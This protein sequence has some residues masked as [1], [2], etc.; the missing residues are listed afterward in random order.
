MDLRELRYFLSVARLRSFTKA[1]LHLR[2]AQ[3]ALSRQVRKLEEELGVPLLVRTGRK[4]ELTRAGMRLFEEGQ[5]LVRAINQLEEDAR[6]E[7][8]ELEAT[9]VIGVPPA[10]GELLMPHILARASERYPG[11]R[12]NIVEG[13]SGFLYERLLN[14]ELSLAL[15]YK[16]APRKDLDI[17]PLVQTQLHLIGPPHKIGDVTPADASRVF[18]DGLP[19]ILPASMHS[20]RVL[21]GE[22]FARHGKTLRLK[23]EVDGLPLT[24]TL[25][26]LGFAFTILT[27]DAVYQQAQA[28]LLSTSLLPGSEFS[29]QLCIA[30]P[31]SRRRSRGVDAVVDIAVGEVRRLIGDGLWPGNPRPIFVSPTG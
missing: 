31:T 6:S 1:S 29:W 14:K 23:L 5:N 10:A 3:P 19:L 7:A 27:Y 30:L 15:L 17:I 25:V 13:H 22:A 21:I 20:P 18:E 8:G 11:L 12:I 16:P 9:V 24:R 26:Q 4:I 28:G 2:I